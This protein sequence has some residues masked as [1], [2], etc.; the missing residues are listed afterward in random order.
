MSPAGPIINETSA[1][2]DSIGQA[3]VIHRSQLAMAPNPNLADPSLPSVQINGTNPPGRSSVTAS[4]AWCASAASPWSS[5]PRA[6][7]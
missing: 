3:Q 7:S 6:S 1:A 5:V 4:P 2:N